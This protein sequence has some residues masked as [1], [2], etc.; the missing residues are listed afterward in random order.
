MLAYSVIASVHQL[1]GILDGAQAKGGISE[2]LE[3]AEKN[4]QASRVERNTSLA[5][6]QSW[7]STTPT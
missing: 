6:K 5:E 3:E 1:V 7:S 4:D 2:E